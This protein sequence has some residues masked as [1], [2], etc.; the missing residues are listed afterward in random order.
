MSGNVNLYVEWGNAS[1]PVATWAA[2]DQN[3]MRNILTGLMGSPYGSVVVPYYD[4]GLP[5]LTI[6]GECTKVDDGNGMTCAQN[7]FVGCGFPT[8]PQGVYVFLSAGNQGLGGNLGCHA[9]GV[10]ISGSGQPRTVVAAVRGGSTHN[11]TPYGDYKIAGQA[12]TLVHE[13]VETITDSDPY[14]AVVITS[15]GWTCN[16]RTNELEDMCESA[17][18]GQWLGLWDGSAAS[19]YNLVIDGSAY[20]VQPNWV[21]GPYNQCLNSIPTPV[22]D[23]FAHCNTPADCPTLSGGFVQG[24][25]ANSCNLP[26]CFDG[27]KD[28]D[29][30]DI[31]CGGEC[32]NQNVYEGGFVPALPCGTGKACRFNADCASNNCSGGVCS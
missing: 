31:D 23:R 1:S 8:D 32:T 6:A 15:T 28:G 25:V 18:G 9:A 5:T 29:E 14:G 3:Y 10:A 19:A 2:A 22:T 20:A 21:K 7:R 11:P 24:C 4:A 27:Q 13:L 17:Y 16:Q 30:S 26:T 12:S